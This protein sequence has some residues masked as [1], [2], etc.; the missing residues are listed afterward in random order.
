[1][2]ASVWLQ[3]AGEQR[4]RL[5]RLIETL[6]GAHGTVPFEPHLTVCG[7]DG[8]DRDAAAGFVKACGLLPFTV[9]K[10][11]IGVSTEKPFKAVVIEVENTP[12]LVRFR[13]SLRQMTDAPPFEPPHISLLYTI[14]AD[15]KRVSWA[16]DV[17][18]LRAIAADCAAAITDTAFGLAEPVIVTPEGDWSNILSWRIVRRL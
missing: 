18:K 16:G 1:M 15:R 8:L 11:E 6:A 17:Q 3:P 7:A 5:R 2:P 4:T 12:E 9:K 13:E 10:R 14:G